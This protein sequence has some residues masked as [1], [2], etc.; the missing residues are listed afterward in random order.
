MISTKSFKWSLWGIFVIL[1]IAQACKINYSFTGA[2]ISPEVKT[3]TVYYMPNRA[4]LVNP[5]LSQ[6][7]T[8]ALQEKL[9]RQT[10]LD[11][12]NDGGDLEFEGQI[13]DYSTQPMNISEGDASAQTRLTVKISV[14]YTNNT[15]HDEDWDKAF[16]AFEDYDSS[17]PLSAV[18]DELMTEIIEKLVEDVFNSSIANW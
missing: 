3:F 16:T 8:E 14:K 9:T 1:V 12:I 17:R 4:P 18:E 13:T 5:S 15:N 10:S 11:M 7:L 6:Q 2:S